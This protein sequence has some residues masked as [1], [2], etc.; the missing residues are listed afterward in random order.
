MDAPCRVAW[1]GRN[2]I[3]KDALFII[4]IMIQPLVFGSRLVCTGKICAS[5]NN[6]FLVEEWMGWVRLVGYVGDGKASGVRWTLQIIRKK[7]KKKKGSRICYRSQQ[8]YG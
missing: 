7:K 8:A 3:G 5:T 4:N 6:I 2:R 1:A